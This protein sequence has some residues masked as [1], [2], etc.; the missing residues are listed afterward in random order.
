MYVLANGG[1]PEKPFAFSVWIRTSTRGQGIFSVVSQEE[2]H[3][4]DRHMFVNQQGHLHLA[5]AQSSAGVAAGLEVGNS[6]SN[7]ASTGSSWKLVNFQQAYHDPVVIAGIPSAKGR[8]EVV[9][10]IRDV[11]STG[12]KFH[13]HET[14]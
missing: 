13:L 12:F 2:A 11:T 7:Q 4:H 5:G 9:V 3:E 6:V 1:I 14:S 8:Q 10:N